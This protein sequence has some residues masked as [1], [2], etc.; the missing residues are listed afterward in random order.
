[1]KQQKTTKNN[2][3]MIQKATK[4]NAIKYNYGVNKQYIGLN[5]LGCYYFIFLSVRAIITLTN[6]ATTL[7]GF[8]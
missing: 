6:T 8:L 2:A 3:M 5:E 1:M 7:N 4:V